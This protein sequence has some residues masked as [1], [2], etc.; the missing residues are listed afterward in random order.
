MNKN[1]TNVLTNMNIRL[2]NINEA[3]ISQINDIYNESAQLKF[4]T[5]DTQ[6]T[7]ITDRIKWLLSYNQT[8]YPVYVAVENNKVFGWIAVRPYREGR[9]A[10]RFTKEVSYYIAHSHH[11]KGIGTMLLNHVVKNASDLQIKNL[12]AIVLEKN[13]GSIRLLEKFN[14][15]KWGVL[16]DVADFGGE[17]CSHLYYGL[18]I[19]SNHGSKKKTKEEWLSELIELIG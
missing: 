12:I 8:E 11:K 19:E 4:L 18:Y 15:S 3:E 5:A 2:A 16:P 7:T 10:L 13:T 9:A 6:P 1:T 14:F 17:I